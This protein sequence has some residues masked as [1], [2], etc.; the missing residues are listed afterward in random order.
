MQKEELLQ[1]LSDYVFD[2]EDEEICEVTQEYID[3][4]FDPQEG[5]L[6]GLVDGMRRASE[7]YEQGEYF[8]PELINCSDAM[9]ASMEMLQNAMPGSQEYIGKAV[10]GVVQGDTHDIG[11]NLVKIMIETAGIHVHDLGRDVPAS[12]FVAYVR[13]NEDVD[14][15]CMSSLMTTTMPGMEAVIK[16]LE[17]EG[18][19]DRVKV[20]VGGAPVSAGFAQRIGADLYTSNAIEAKSGAVSLLERMR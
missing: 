8:V 2:M 16:G 10:I 11:K 17:E 5:I 14:L 19:R 1:K 9:Y 4:G 13:Y 3:A 18:I 6:E 7:M 12:D 15:V 20:M